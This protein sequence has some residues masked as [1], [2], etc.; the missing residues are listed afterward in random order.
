MDATSSKAPRAAVALVAL[1][2]AAC[3]GSGGG[4]AP[5][6]YTVGGTVTGWSGSGLVLRDN[7]DDDFKITAN[8]AFTFAT[9]LTSGTAY[10]A[11]VATQPTSPIQRCRI[12]NGSGTVSAG[13]ITSISVTCKT[14]V[15]T[16]VA[17]SFTGPGSVDGTG[18][19]ARFNDATGIAGWHRV[20]FRG[21]GRNI[22]EC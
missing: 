21:H 15:L 16:V 6:T 18:A 3:G 9:R 22:R 10:A 11:S 1:V 17:G 4:V 19:E 13:N 7:G 12:S 14:P 2:L 20:D 8:G 5:T